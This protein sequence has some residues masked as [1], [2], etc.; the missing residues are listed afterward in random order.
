MNPSHVVLM[1]HEAMELLRR[2]DVGR[3]CVVDGEYPI[4]VPVNY[5]L[6]SDGDIQIVVIQTAATATIARATGNASLEVD[7]ID[8]AAGT[9]WSVIARG[10]LK[11]AYGD[12]GLPGTDPVVT[13]D[14]DQWLALEI[15][16]LSGRRFNVTPR[17]PPAT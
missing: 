16:A 9:A 11:H 1:R 13:A 17:T 5:R 12:H 4:A 2:H 14:R 10:V 8:L 6:H 15:V 7:H 3:L